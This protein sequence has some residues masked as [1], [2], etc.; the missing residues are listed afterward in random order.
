[1]TVM[2]LQSGTATTE[3]IYRKQ[4]RP[5]IIGGAEVMDRL[6][7]GIPQKL[8]RMPPVLSYSVGYSIRKGMTSAGVSWPVSWVGVAGFEPAAS[9]SRTPPP[10]E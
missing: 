4:I 8:G 5:V 10:R 6:F 1:M 2:D 7:P 9:S 3:T